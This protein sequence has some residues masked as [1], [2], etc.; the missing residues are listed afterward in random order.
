MSNQLD[1]LRGIMTEGEQ[2]F[3]PDYESPP[4]NEVVCGVS[5]EKLENL[6]GP[7]LGLFWHIVRE[8]FPIIEHAP[9]LESGRPD[10][11]FTN[12]MPRMWFIN[13]P[14]NMLIQLQNNRFYFNWR[15]MQDDEA[16]PRYKNIIKAFKHN[17]EIFN[18][19][20]QK[21]GVGSISIENCELTYINQI[22]KG[23]GWDTLGDI[24]GVFRDFSWFTGQRFLP[25]PIGIGGQAQFALPDEKG[26][27]QVSL[28]YGTRKRPPKHPILILQMAATGLGEDNS[29]E[30]VWEWFELAHE[31]IVRG[32]TDLTEN[33]IQ[34]EI[35]KRS[36]NK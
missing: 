9:R 11:D 6:K 15:R 2:T 31:W 25:T 30:G 24:S 14:Q 4:V 3:L 19:F 17:L 18:D 20:L 32:F 1:V 28:Q 5:F 16:Y 34:D 23:E 21:E 35:W 36:D 26:Q 12:Y 13:A 7:H 10:I 27:L 22:P 8:S 33:R 29:R